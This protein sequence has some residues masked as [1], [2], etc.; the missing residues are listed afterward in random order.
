MTA[1][2]FYTFFIQLVLCPVL[3]LYLVWYL[4]IGIMVWWNAR[5]SA[6]KIAHVD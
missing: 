3:M 4:I 2:A 5:S 1:L 6:A